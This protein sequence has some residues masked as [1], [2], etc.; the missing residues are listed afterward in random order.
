MEFRKITFENFRE[1][2]KLSA[3]E[4]SEMFVAP[5]SISLAQAYI[6]IENDACKP[7]PFGVFKGET[8]VGFIMMD[9][10]REDQDEDLNE[11]IY[12]I[13]R[14]MIDVNYQGKG[15]GKE[16]LL[17]A[18]EYIKT[19]PEGPSESCFL[20]YVPGN[21]KAEELYKSVGFVETGVI[22]DGEIQMKLSI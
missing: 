12:E 13:W 2:K 20:S 15:Y 1:C 16:A 3:G 8:M 14:F 10:I 4:N 22:D 7:M 21:E 17:K 6:A 11:N 18:I 9:Y 5:N 19:K